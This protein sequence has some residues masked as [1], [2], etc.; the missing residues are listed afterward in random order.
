MHIRALRPRPRGNNLES[1]E[2]MH[3]TRQLDST[4]IAL[5]QITDYACND[6]PTQLKVL[7]TPMVGRNCRFVLCMFVLYFVVVTFSPV[8]YV[9]DHIH[10]E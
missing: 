8:R 7:A 3:A 5:L 10:L 6:A 2:S 9:D 1:P 4:C